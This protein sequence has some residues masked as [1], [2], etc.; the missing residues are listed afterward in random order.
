MTIRRR[1][2]L[3]GTAAL[4]A[5]A[6]AAGGVATS[7]G[8]LG[9]DLPRAG[10][11][12]PNI[13]LIVAD[14]MRADAM[15]WTGNRFIPTPALDRLGAES[16]CFR[17]NFVT[18]SICPTSRASIITGLYGSSHGVW[19]F[20]VPLAPRWEK[21]ALP[22]QL[23]N[24]G[25]YTGFVGKWG[26][27]KPESHPSHLFD[28]FEAQPDLAPY[29]DKNRTPEHLTDFQAQT[30]IDLLKQRPADKPFM[31]MLSFRAPHD[32]F[33]PA[34]RFNNRLAGLDLPPP[35]TMTQAAFDSR[36]ALVREHT[37]RQK[38]DA[39]FRDLATYRAHNRA[40]YR[41][42]LGID[43]AVGQLLGYLDAENIRSNTCVIFTSD[44]GLQMG[45]F[46][47]FGKT[48]GYEPAIRTPMML[49]LPPAMNFERRLAGVGALTLN[50]DIA[51]TLFQLAGIRKPPAM[52]GRS[53]LS[54]ARH[55]EPADWRNDFLYEQYHSRWGLPRCEGVRG[56]ELKYMRYFTEDRGE[57]EM[58][59]LLA[60][61]LEE[62]NVISRPELQ[63]QVEAMTTRLSELKKN[64]RT[65]APV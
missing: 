58:Y 50:V 65:I 16:L 20:D 14:D 45:E 39:P 21:Q 5:L 24:A 61:P 32:V 27:G 13:I 7:L 17:N 47:R 11:K 29:M 37:L 18:T 22:V 64:I 59:D 52:H 36:P 26:I 44:N 51:P 30:A 10:N 34:P 57:D 49:S 23:R 46:M 55:S 41:L 12:Q 15:S 6:G 31:L 63:G 60:D 62:R 2:F 3:T 40:Y 53:L 54:F 56:K 19:D 42:I 9:R 8:W 33:E 28:R 35:V 48:F 43:Q 38:E 1:D 4:G 25:Y